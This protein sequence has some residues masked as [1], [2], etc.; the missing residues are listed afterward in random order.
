M[1]SNPST[2]LSKTYTALQSTL[3]PTPIL[4]TKEQHLLSL[5]AEEQDLLLSISL[6]AAHTQTPLPNTTSTAADLSTAQTL[7]AEARA[8]HT[9]QQRIITRALTAGPLATATHAPSTADRRLVEGLRARDAYSMCAAAAGQ[10]VQAAKER[11]DEM[12]REG[13]GKMVENEGMAQ[14]MLGM[15]EEVDAEKDGL[16]RISVEMKERIEREERAVRE[17]RAEWRVLKG[18]AGGIVVASGMDWASEPELVGVVAD[19]EME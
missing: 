11:R 2:L 4:T 10:A 19:G 12:E 5:L 7:A 13:R 16:D 18:L 15:A 1:D 14:R 8:R 3:P 17:A 9:L 6:A